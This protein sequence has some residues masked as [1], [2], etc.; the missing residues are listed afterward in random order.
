MQRRNSVRWRA[1]ADMHVNVGA[2]G[3]GKDKGH[4]AFELPAE[5]D[6]LRWTV[7]KDFVSGFGPT[8]FGRRAH[9]RGGCA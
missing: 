2:A 4:L 6:S 5:T 9:S 8:P 3:G 7:P 1:P